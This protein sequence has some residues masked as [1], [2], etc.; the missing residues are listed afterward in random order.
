MEQGE[1]SEGTILPGPQSEKLRMSRRPQLGAGE[2]GGKQL[3]GSCCIRLHGRGV[4]T[5]THQDSADADLISSMVMVVSTE[6]GSRVGVGGG[7]VAGG[8]AAAKGLEQCSVGRV[9]G[10][11]G[12]CSVDMMAA[13]ACGDSSAVSGYLAAT[14]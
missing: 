10:H 3:L 4:G 13:P 11:E 9:E 6:R 1:G 5:S 8:M 7:D 12:Q 2:T 14:V